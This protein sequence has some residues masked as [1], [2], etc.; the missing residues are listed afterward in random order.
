MS[1][2][3]ILMK[4]FYAVIYA[5]YLAFFIWLCIVASR[6]QYLPGDVAISDWFS[7][8]NLSFA[9][10]VMQVFSAVG[11]TISVV[12]IVLLII[13]LLW[14]YNRRLEALFLAIL[15]SV[16]G[17]TT[18]LLKELIDRPRPGITGNAGLSFPSG[19]TANSA[20][21]FGLLFYLLP[22]LINKPVLTRILRV[23]IIIHISLVAVSRVYLGE[24]WP[25]DILGGVLLGCLILIPGILIYRYLKER[26][27]GKKEEECRSYR[28]LKL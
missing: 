17:V 15:P 5:A 25:S 14:F 16:T 21:L 13:L 22:H 23:I 4:G 3:G 24:H 19:H 8:L 18:W 1:K 11:E 20:L 7:R 28:K 27:G 6:G 10:D 26:K 2:T 12:L 9:E